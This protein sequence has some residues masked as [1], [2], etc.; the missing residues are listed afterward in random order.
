MLTC[1]N[2]NKTRQ[3]CPSCILLGSGP[4]PAPEQCMVRL[5]EGKWS[6]GAFG[7]QVVELV[8]RMVHDL[9]E[10]T[11]LVWSSLSMDGMRHE[12]PGHPV[13]CAAH[14]CRHTS[15]T[16]L[17]R[18]GCMHSCCRKSPLIYFCRLHTSCDTSLSSCAVR[19]SNGAMAGSGPSPKERPKL[20]AQTP[21]LSTRPCSR[22]LEWSDQLCSCAMLARTGRGSML[23]NV[24]ETGTS[25]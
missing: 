18:L 17:H 4:A 3:T 21:S 13:F 6:V 19:S 14:S 23:A 7:M 24:V 9:T 12:V 15:K 1:P 22:S 8:A 16:A 10:G 11:A 25:L 5:K 20:A 2:Q